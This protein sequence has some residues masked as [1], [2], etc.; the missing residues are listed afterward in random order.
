MRNQVFVQEQ[1]LLEAVRRK[2]INETQMQEVLSISRAMGQQRNPIDLGWITGVQSVIIGGVA[3]VPALIALE[4]MRRNAPSESLLYSLVAVFGLLF[5]SW[6]IRSRGLGKAPAGIAAAGASLWCWG[7]GASLA[8]M[9]LFP[10]AFGSSDGYSSY[11]VDYRVSIAQRHYVFLAGDLAMLLGSLAI[12]R[13]LRM[14]TT[15]ATAALAMVAGVVNWVEASERTRNAY[16]SDSQASVMLLVA[17]ALT[18]AIGAGVQHFTRKSRLDPAFWLFSVGIVPL[19]FA[20]AIMIDKDAGMAL[21]WT[22]AA[23]ATIAAGVYFDRK[24]IIVAGATALLFYPPF[25]AAEAHMGD[26]AVGMAFTVSAILVAVAVMIV[27]TVY[28]ARAAQSD[29]SNEQDVWG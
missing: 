5:A 29:A 19:G 22:L 11:E 27:R 13:V 18:L 14:P 28:V 21:P 16:V 6:L 9:F 12:G 2:V 26:G 4:R 17:S 3:V 25:G 10:H 15:A 20:G 24:A 8:G 23:A 7:I 1:H